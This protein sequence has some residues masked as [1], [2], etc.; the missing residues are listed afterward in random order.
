MTY[1][2]KLDP[3]NPDPPVTISLNYSVHLEI[4]G[5]EQISWIRLSIAKIPDYDIYP[6]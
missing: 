4:L 5:F 3:M 1:L 6:A 2:I